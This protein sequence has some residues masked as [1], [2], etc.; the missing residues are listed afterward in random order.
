MTKTLCFTILLAV[1]IACY[2]DDTMAEMRSEEM[3]QTKAQAYLAQDNAV[4]MLYFERIHKITA[5]KAIEIAGRAKTLFDSEDRAASFRSLSVATVIPVTQPSIQRGRNVAIDTLMH[6][7][8]YSNGGG[9]AVISAD[10]R[11]GEIIAYSGNGNFNIEDT[12]GNAG[13]KLH[14]E[15]MLVYQKSKF[16]RIADARSRG[17]YYAGEAVLE[18]Q[19]M[20]DTPPATTFGATGQPGL[21]GLPGTVTIPAKYTER[22]WEGNFRIQAVA[23]AKYGTSNYFGAMKN[24][25]IINFGTGEKPYPGQPCTTT[26][27]YCN[28]ILANYDDYY[29]Y[30]GCRLNLYTS[31]YNNLDDGSITPLMKT[32][33]DQDT[34]LN[35]GA[36]GNNGNGPHS[37]G[38][39][40][41]AVAQIMAYHK[42]PLSYYSQLWGKTYNTYFDI[43]S[44]LVTNADI[45]SSGYGQMAGAFVRELGHRM[46]VTYTKNGS[47]VVSL[48]T[49]G[50]QKIQDTFTS[51][52]YTIGYDGAW[53]YETAGNF[54]RVINS[55]K[56]GLPVFIYGFPSGTLHPKWTEGHIWV[57]DG[58]KKTHFRKDKKICYFDQDGDFNS[59]KSEYHTMTLPQEYVHANLGWGTDWKD[60]WVEK[61]CYLFGNK[62]NSDHEYDG[63]IYFIAGIR[64]PSN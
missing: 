3:P 13:A 26:R 34:P 15:L 8:N 63:K 45:E 64:P 6:I 60:L 37:A 23:Q 16:Q 2:K 38:C 46:D 9:F 24:P 30:Y 57:L 62:G 27:P 40:P 28:P 36:Y 41:I 5:D 14:L 61:G 49:S 42:K 58:Y 20:N 33:W 44:K 47:A 12:A 10:D 29:Y 22:F 1:M 32:Y 31:S 18:N 52:G 59:V 53:N 50:T 48:A 35:F 7:V 43:T 39:G 54:W 21:P 19:A 55:I 56:D 4:K 11:D 25:P 17:E 51:F